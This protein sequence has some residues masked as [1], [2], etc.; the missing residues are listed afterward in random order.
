[1]R[2]PTC[3]P[4]VDTS[5]GVR[6]GAWG[7]CPPRAITNA[8]AG[9]DRVRSFNTSV[10][11]DTMR[12]IPRVIE[13]I[14]GI[15]MSQTANQGI[16]LPG[17]VFLLIVAANGMLAAAERLRLGLVA[18]ALM[19]ALAIGASVGSYAFAARHGVFAVKDYEAKYPWSVG[20]SRPTLPPTQSSSRRSIAAAFA[21]MPV[22]PL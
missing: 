9:A 20:G 22:E 10:P 7:V 3:G 4:S 14:V 6:A 17:L 13:K 19:L 8:S 15:L 16:R 21:F 18:N 11:E 2:S 12:A 5:T 1:M